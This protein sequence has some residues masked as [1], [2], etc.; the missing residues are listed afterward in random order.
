[1]DAGFGFGT[2]RTVS[3]LQKSL[4]RLKWAPQ[5]NNE[6][7]FPLPG[8]PGLLAP[9]LGFAWA[10]QEPKGHSRKQASCCFC[11]ALLCFRPRGH[12][13]PILS[14]SA[15]SCLFYIYHISWLPSYVCFCCSRRCTLLAISRRRS[16]R[17]ICT[18]PPTRFRQRQVPRPVPWCR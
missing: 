10:K 15:E 17:F 1:M 18:T 7:V 11:Q 2:S 8:K 13:Q 5:K 12:V 4:P 16:T 6:F 14:T 9:L 3:F